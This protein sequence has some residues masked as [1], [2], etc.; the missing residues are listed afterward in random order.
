[1]VE[2]E[3][4]KTQLEIQD[5]T[6]KNIGQELHDNVGQLLSFTS[7]QLNLVSSL[8]K[9]GIKE[10]IEDTKEVV[11]DTI[12]EV[13][14]LSKSLNSDVILNLGLKQSIQN[15]VNRLNKLKTIEAELI[16]EGEEAELINKKDEII[17]FR[18]RF[19]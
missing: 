15:E 19:L 14:A 16:I 5:Q 11:K 2:E 9:D 13:R 1:M 6:L 3:I 10:K 8:A 7:M 18:I 17:L 4:A 12:Q